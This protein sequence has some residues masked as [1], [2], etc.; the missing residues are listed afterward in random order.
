MVSDAD[1]SQVFVNTTGGN[2][3][4]WEMK[5]SG[6]PAAYSRALHVFEKRPDLL[7]VLGGDT[8]NGNGFGGMS[9]SVESVSALLWGTGP[10]KGPL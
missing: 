9:L 4:G 2:P 1:S 3:E 6:Q 5:Q 8:F 10:G 7:M